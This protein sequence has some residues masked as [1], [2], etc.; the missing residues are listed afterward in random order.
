MFS[1][2]ALLQVVFAE[3]DDMYFLEGIIRTGLYRYLWYQLHDKYSSVYFV[4]RDEQQNIRVFHY[5]ES[6]TDS[7]KTKSF[8]PKKPEK[9][10][11]KWLRKQLKDQK[12]RSAVVFPLDSFCRMFRKEEEELSEIRAEKELYGTIILIASTNVTKSAQW[13]LTSPVFDYLNERAILSL[14]TYDGNIYDCLKSRKQEAC[15]FLNTYTRER[16]AD[17]VHYLVLESNRF[18]GRCDM[19]NLIDYLTQYM[20]NKYMQMI[21]KRIFTA[22]FGLINPLYKDL[23]RQLKD[24]TVWNALVSRSREDSSTLKEYLA[25]HYINE[26][27]SVFCA[28][29]DDETV[30]MR[31]MKLCFAGAMHHTAYDEPAVDKL[32]RIYQ[33]VAHG[34]SREKNNGIQNRLSMFIDKLQ[35]AQNNKD[36]STCSRVVSAILFCVRWLYCDEESQRDVMP[37]I[38]AFESYIQLSASCYAMQKNYCSSSYQY[39]NLERNI[40]QYHKQLEQLDKVISYS[41]LNLTVSSTKVDISETFRNMNRIMKGVAVVSP[42]V[43]T[44]PVALATETTEQGDFQRQRQEQRKV[45]KPT[46]NISTQIPD[47]LFDPGVP[48]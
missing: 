47:S 19:E 43:E 14:R 21:T 6:Y 40:Q 7:L 17:M 12:H 18:T 15:V 27:G 38:E 33:E 36:S 35:T 42:V 11:V 28:S 32:N 31:C 34:N 16:V 5:E 22:D 4:D 48:T 2:N 26:N 24:K 3:P 45:Q 20:N 10:L 30:E 25:H 8:F 39:E 41:I 9:N 44:E 1:S 46:Y 37:I 29:Y 13:L 23:Y